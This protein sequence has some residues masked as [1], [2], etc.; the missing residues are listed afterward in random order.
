MHHVQPTDMEYVDSIKDAFFKSVAQ[1]VIITD[2]KN[3]DETVTMMSASERLE[4]L[5]IAVRKKVV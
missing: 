2:A 3:G 5:E 1:Q 4:N